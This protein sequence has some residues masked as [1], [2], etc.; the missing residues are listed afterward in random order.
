MHSA[1]GDR[2]TKTARQLSNAPHDHIRPET[3][4]NTHK[5]LGVNERERDRE[6]RVAGKANVVKR[7][8]ILLM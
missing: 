1:A 5:V 7:V 6:M 2:N 8:G 3:R 4:S